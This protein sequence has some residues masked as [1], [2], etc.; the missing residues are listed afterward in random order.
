M[1]PRP[2]TQ[3][4]KKAGPH[5]SIMTATKKP[6]R[7]PLNPSFSSGPCA[8]RPGWSPRALDGALVG[9]SHRSAEGRARLK[10]VIQRTKAIL[11][12]PVGYE[13]ALVPGSDT[14]AFEMAMWNLLG[15]RGVDV[16]AWEVFGRIWL[17]D[18][19]EELKLAD[20]RTF[21]ADWGALPDLSQADF[22]RDVIFTWNG[23]TS[24]VRVPDANWIPDNRGGLT[25]CDAT[26]AV[27]AQTIDLSKI[28]VLTYSWQKVLGGEAA[29]G[30]LV[31]SPRAIDRLERY[32]PTWPIPKILR[33]KSNGKVLKEVFEGVTI[34]TPSM[35]CLED[36]ADAL[37]WAEGLGGTDGLCARADANAAVIY[38]W[39]A[40]TSWL[41]PLADKP[42][43]RSN[44]SLCL[45][46][47]DPAIVAKG[48]KAALE[49][50]SRISSLLEQE[51]AA[52]DILAY[53]GVPPGLRIWT[54]AT[55]ARD[56]LVLL[57]EWLDWAFSAVKAE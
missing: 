22:S 10:D 7:K 25:M 3:D 16:F 11:R 26:S 30:M 2:R 9:R 17:K 5:G 27:F 33:L 53:R 21:E 47:S 50:A 49:F 6:T 52:Y 23:T 38:E 48:E 39:A 20:L 56:D 24:G 55:I 43:T 31:L 40:R 4:S 41:T 15:P 36:Y 42:E 34:N 18:A 28:D 1:H 54:G 32:D 44:T 46:L 12:L 45:R 29:H 35:L 51:G 57:T 13:V 8:K 37:A 14:G 19:L